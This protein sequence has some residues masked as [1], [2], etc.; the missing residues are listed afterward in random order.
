[1]DPGN[2]ELHILWYTYDEAGRLSAIYL[3]EGTASTTSPTNNKKLIRSYA[4]NAYGEIEKITD[5]TSFLTGGT[6]TTELAYTYNDYGLPVKLTYTDVDGET[7]TVR[8]ETNLTYDGNG[9]ILTEAVTEAYSGS[10]TK[11]RTYQYDLGNRLISAAYEGTATAYTYDAVGNR[12]TRQEG[13]ETAET[14]TYNYLNQ[15]TRV[16]Q[17]TAVTTYTYDARGEPDA[18]GADGDGRD[19][20]EHVRLRSGQPA[21]LVGHL[22]QRGDPAVDERDVCVQRAGAARDARGGRGRH[23]LLLHGLRAAVHD[24]ERVRIADAEHPRPI[25]HDRGEQAVRGAGDHRAGPVCG[26]LLLLPVRR[27]RERHEHR[28][29]GR[30]RSSSPTTTTSSA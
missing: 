24:G 26:G 5:N 13:T 16:Q 22:E 15:L 14:Y 7:R 2:T 9:N 8:E 3:D 20:D 21:D 19:D 17:G 18:A 25:G 11:T 23:A 1:M 30:P 10:T 6:L 12:L 4:Y 27:A 28:G 29:R